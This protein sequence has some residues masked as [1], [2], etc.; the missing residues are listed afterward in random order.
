MNHLSQIQAEFVKEAR[1][2][3]DMSAEDQKAYLK[4]HPKSKRKVTGGS[5]TVVVS[6]KGTSKELAT[7][8]DTTIKRLNKRVIRSEKDIISLTRRID[9]IKKS[10]LEE[11][12][13]IPDVRDSINSEK[14]MLKMYSG[15]V[16]DMK[17]IQQ[18]IKDGEYKKA[19]KKMR[20][21]DTAVREEI[22]SYMFNRLEKL[23]D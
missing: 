2:W 3:E 16:K 1:K 20:Y 9:Y 5:K 21:L 7:K 18:L 12:D 17:N 22:P 23:V 6:P 10:D 13:Q 4:R 11:N 8:L 14:A 19:L 15:D